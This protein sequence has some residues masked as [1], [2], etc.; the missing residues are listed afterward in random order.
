MFIFYKKTSGWWHSYNNGAKEVNLSDWNI[1]LDDV[2][3]T[4]VLQALNGSNIPKQA[5]GIDDVQVIDETDASVVE[6]FVSVELLRTRLT[7]LNYSPYL[8]NGA[9]QS[10]VAGTNVTVD[11]TDP[12]NPIV[13]ASGGGGG[14]QDLQS[15]LDEGGFAQSPD[16]VSY[17][18]INLDNVGA[19]ID[20][21]FG[22]STEYSTFSLDENEAKMSHTE[23]GKT[24][25]IIIPA[26][27][28]DTNFS[29]QSDKPT[30]DY[31]LATLDDITPDVTNLGYTPSPTNGIVTSDTGT[32]ATLPLADAT[33]AGLLKPAKYTVLENTSGTNSGDNATNSQY[34]GLAASKE[35][36]SNKENSTLDYDTTKYPTVNLV[37]TSLDNTI[38]PYIEITDL[39]GEAITSLSSARAFIENFTFATKTNE[40]FIAAGGGGGIYRFTVPYDSDF[41]LAHNFCSATT[42]TPN[43]KVDDSFGLMYRFGNGAFAGNTQN[44]ILNRVAG[45]SFGDNAFDGATPSI[46]NTIYSVVNLGADGFKDYIGRVDIR[47]FGTDGTQT[48]PADIFT[49]ASL[50][51]IVTDYANKYNDSGSPDA[52]IVQAIANM[53][54]GN[55]V[56]SYD[57]VDET[58]FTGMV[59]NVSFQD[60]NTSITAQT[61]VLELYAQYAYT[62][63]EL[64]II[65]GLGTCTAAVKINGTN[66]TGI[67][68]VSVSTTIATGTSSAANTVA[69]GDKITLVITSPSTLDNLQASLKTTR[70]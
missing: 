30:G 65:S 62:I 50:V 45:T 29:L 18:D 55:S 70:I 22:T 38:A 26:S 40:S 59:E 41:D 51:W 47:K 42:S 20:M 1:V 35:N 17:I 9:I 67:S 16:T 7:A 2:T 31:I 34:S 54:N 28:N 68:A 44:N 13:S 23:A 27:D 14:S 5:V 21:S 24:N 33:N 10:I 58:V 32:D 11:N 39:L 63:N 37:K 61:Y 60:S 53:S 52:D 12:L 3:Q 43:I 46:T 48:L 56:V 25:R 57:G 19:N 36:V 8:E 66:V 64:K 15:V 6:T 49:T 4:V 69:V